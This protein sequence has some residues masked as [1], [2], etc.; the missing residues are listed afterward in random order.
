MTTKQKIWFA[1]FLAMFAVPEVLWSPVSDFYYEFWQSGK[2]GNIIPL[3]QNFLNNSDNVGILKLV[4]VIQ[5][6]SLFIAFGILLVAKFNSKIIKRITIL[7][8][9]ILIFLVGFMVL[10]AFNFNPKI[11]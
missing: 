5:L 8:L 7:L 11:G 10:F 1:I 6:L 2:I 9:I 3:R 4:I